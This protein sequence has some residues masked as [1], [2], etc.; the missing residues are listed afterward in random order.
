M[1][2][3]QGWRLLDTVGRAPTRRVLG[4]RSDTPGGS[5]RRSR[6]RRRPRTRPTPR[7]QDRHRRPRDARLRRRDPEG[8]ARRPST[9]R[10]GADWTSARGGRLTFPSEGADHD[11]GQ[12]RADRV[13][14]VREVRQRGAIVPDSARV[15]RGEAEPMGASRGPARPRDPSRVRFWPSLMKNTRARSAVAP[16]AA[17]SASSPDLARISSDADLPIHRSSHSRP[18]V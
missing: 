11:G 12:G 5:C 10:G 15:G 3:R 17:P 14:V 6:I 1:G 8:G 16:A 4:R 9:P 18:A 13:G 2:S 7:R